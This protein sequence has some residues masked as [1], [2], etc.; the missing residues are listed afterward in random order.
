[1]KTR[2]LLEL[3]KLKALVSP[4]KSVQPEER[5]VGSLA[6]L[7]R[8]LDF[9]PHGLCKSEAIFL[10]FLFFFLFEGGWD[11]AASDEK[12]QLRNLHLS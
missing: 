9:L 10:S 4:L 2:R 8:S 3:T 5:G 7:V 12:Y 1:M 6:S 11:G